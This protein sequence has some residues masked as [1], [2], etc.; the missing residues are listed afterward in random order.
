MDLRDL[1]VY[2][3]LFAAFV[4]FAVGDFLIFIIHN[5]LV[6]SVLI[7]IGILVAIFGIFVLVG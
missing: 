4:F 5:S 6:G 3:I 2:L 7:W 1:R